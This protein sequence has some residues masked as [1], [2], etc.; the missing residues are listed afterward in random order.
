M[1]RRNTQLAWMAL[2]LIGWLAACS[3]DLECTG[4]WCGTV[5]VVSGAEPEVLLPPLAQFDTHI[6]LADLIFWRLADVKPRATTVGDSGFVPRLADHWTLEDSLTISFHLNPA[7]KWHDGQPVRATDVVFTFGVYRS[8][9]INALARERIGK[10][11]SVTARD[12]LTAVF[13]FR[14]HYPEQFFDAVYHMRIIP[15]HLLKDIPYAE[16]ASAPFARSPIGNGPFMF[17]K[18]YAG[19]SI[20]LAA[21]STFF[22]GRP[23]LRR[24]IWRFSSDPQTMVSQLIA[25]EVDFLNVIQTP[26]DVPQVA[27][28]P[29]LRTQSY[30]LGVYTYIAFNFRDPDDPNRPHPLFADRGLRRAITKAVDRESIVKAVLDETA[31]VPVGPLT[32][33]QWIW[34]DDIEGIGFDRAAARRELQRM[35]W[36]D[37]DG[38]GILDRHGRSLSFELLVVGTSTGRKRSAVIIQDQLKQVGIAMS[39]TE[40]EPNSLGNRVTKGKFDTYFGGWQQDPSPASIEETWTSTAIGGPNYGGYSNPSVDRMVHNALSTFNRDSARVEWQQAIEM[41]NADAPAIWVYAPTPVA[42]LH[43]RLENVSF[44][45]DE[46]WKTI[47]QWRVDPSRVIDRDLIAAN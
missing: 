42:G 14:E 25:G 36:Q 30:L 46:W 15:E 26:E 37:T 28:R 1:I 22:A 11:A 45:P 41:I 10:I 3:P 18:W 39:I 19:R 24:L 27:K 31:E 44:A 32:R 4:D 2:P 13:R 16:L 40:L 9:E 34:S 35:G 29:H 8:P 43:D 21:D 17:R 12:S 47:W 33:A 5:V 23:G 38:D 7:A 20:E 6:A